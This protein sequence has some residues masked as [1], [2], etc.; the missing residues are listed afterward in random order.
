MSSG[1]QLY[2]QAA[3]VLSANDRQTWTAPARG[4]Y[5]HQWLWDSCFIAIGLAK[6]NPSRAVIELLSLTRGQWSNGMLPGM[7]Y[8]TAVIHRWE[9]GIWGDQVESPP[10]VTTSALTQPPLLA[11]AVSLVAETLTAVARRQFLDTIWPCLLAY[12]GWLYRE[13]DP[14]GSGLVSLVHPWESGWEDTPYWNQ[15]MSK[16]SPIH[17]SMGLIYWLRGFDAGERASGDEVGHM[18]SQ[19]KLLEQVDFDSRR[20]LKQSAVQVQDLPFNAL[21]I[22]SNRALAEMGEQYGYGVPINLTTNF[23]AAEAALDELWDPASQQYYSRDRLTGQL[24]KRP[25]SATFVPLYAGVAP[26]R[27]ARLLK[28]LLTRPGTYWAH[29]PVP[30]VPVSDAQ[31]DERRYWR[32][33]TWVN[34]NWLIIRGLEAYGW[35]TEAEHLRTT[36]TQMIARSGFREYYSALTGDGLGAHDFSWTAALY[37][38][39]AGNQ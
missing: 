29:Y 12:H 17:T 8:D 18:R 13:R 15:A 30:S 36:T 3:A 37:L 6:I 16:V 4:P 5:P 31:Y 27:R 25:T 24:I 2:E 11:V 34:L 23:A 28:N 9:A 7:I 20:M 21:L 1:D 22:A 38:D 26:L 10:G 35:T 19:L 14:D 39:L 32:G 33:P